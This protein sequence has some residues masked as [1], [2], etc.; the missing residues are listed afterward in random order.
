[1]NRMLI[2][3]LSLVAAVACSG[4]PESS[5]EPRSPEDPQ[6]EPPPAT[7]NEIDP[8][9]VWREIRTALRAD[10]SYLRFEAERLVEQGDPSALHAFVRDRIRPVPGDIDAIDA[11][12]ASIGGLR[13]TLRSGT[14]TLRDKAELLRDLLER[15]GFEAETRTSPAPENLAD[16]FT[17]SLPPSL[18]L[19]E[20]LVQEWLQDV[21]ETPD[22]VAPSDPGG[23]RSQA[24]AQ[25]IFDALPDSIE[26]PVF[27]PTAPSRM[28]IVRYRATPSD[29]WSFADLAFSDSDLSDAPTF[30]VSSALQEPDITFELN[31]FTSRSDGDSVSILS[32]EF[33]A[34]T[35]V[36]RQVAIAT[37]PVD[38]LAELWD[39]PMESV[40]AFVPSF[41]LQGIDV[42]DD[43]AATWSFIGSTFTQA[44]D[45][46]RVND[47][48]DLTLNGQTFSP[49][50]D[51]NN[52][53]SINEVEMSVNSTSFPL[54]TLRLTAQDMD[55]IA[56]PGLP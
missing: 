45:V 21:G 47:D 11:T 36:G 7:D 3:W 18:S 51:P 48:G 14:G 23:S 15:A 31:L 43:L 30:T 44:G 56:V 16:I 12:R 22:R 50:S 25:R 53:G 26:A 32:A 34:E 55:G 33:P 52:T 29:E 5:E 10:P 35:L 13:H 1:M 17:S 19:D 38:E 37:A 46:Y 40:G 2:L 4:D 20:A 28:A 27:D 6:G 39:Q 41:S 8:F 49:L 9:E 42:D 24:L 54:V